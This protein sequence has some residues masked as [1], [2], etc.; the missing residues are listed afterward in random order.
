MMMNQRWWVEVMMMMM[1]PT[2]D[3]ADESLQLDLISPSAESSETFGSGLWPLRKKVIYVWL[4]AVFSVL[5]WLSLHSPALVS[6]TVSMEQRFLDAQQMNVT[7]HPQIWSGSSELLWQGNWCLKP[8]GDWA[9][10]VCAE[11]SDGG[12]CVLV[13]H[14]IMG[15]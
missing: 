3:A 15:V 5:S 9:P 1:T 14:C 8:I 10:S 7:L 13:W 11:F 4:R 12:V 6:V 2:G